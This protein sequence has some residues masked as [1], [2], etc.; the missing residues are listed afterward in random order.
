MEPPG[1]AKAKQFVSII[2]CV[3]LSLRRLLF[4]VVVPGI[5]AVDVALWNSE[6]SLIRGGA[7]LKNLCGS[8]TK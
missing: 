8:E 2:V 6:T 1:L 4:A 5:I 7:I 3:M